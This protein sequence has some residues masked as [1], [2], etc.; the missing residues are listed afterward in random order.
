[1]TRMM[2]IMRYCH[3]HSIDLTFANK[4]AA[5][6]V[7]LEDK[8]GKEE[9]I[10]DEPIA[11]HRRERVRDVL[12]DLLET[13]L[14][15]Q[16]S[17]AAM[18][19]HLR[20]LKR[21]LISDSET[22]AEAKQNLVPTTMKQ[23]MKLMSFLRDETSFYVACCCPCSATDKECPE[24]GK[25]LWSGS[26][27]KA[28]FFHRQLRPFIKKMLLVDL[29]SKAVASYRQRSSMGDDYADYLDGEY[30]KELIANGTNSIINLSVVLTVCRIETFRPNRDFGILANWD[31]F[32]PFKDQSAKTM[33][34]ANAVFLFLPPHLRISPEFVFVW[35]GVSRHVSNLNL[36]LDFAL[37]EFAD[38]LEKGKAKLSRMMFFFFF[39]FFFSYGFFV[40][41]SSLVVCTDNRLLLLL[42]TC[43]CPAQRQITGEKGPG[44]KLGCEKCHSFAWRDPAI[45]EKIQRRKSTIRRVCTS[46]ICRIVYLMQPLA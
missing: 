44:A 42:A 8:K 23:F 12:L 7:Y 46:S 11:K 20:I 38:S 1:M 26:R 5:L 37:D 14:T 4:N 9:A 15:K 19:C 13:M 34:V 33:D 41:R 27:P 29:I 40:S 16:L 24:C 3:E 43:D 32:R 39:F 31:G 2:Q 25:A 6:N 45:D 28:L 35:W 36:F 22:P 10:L 17:K 18:E 30:I 21:A